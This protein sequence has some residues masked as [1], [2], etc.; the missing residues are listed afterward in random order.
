MDEDE[1]LDED[2]EEEEED[3]DIDESG[4]EYLRNAPQISA[5]DVDIKIVRQKMSLAESSLELIRV[6]AIFNIF[7][8]SIRTHHHSFLTL[9]VSE[10]QESWRKKAARRCTVENNIWLFQSACVSFIEE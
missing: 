9:T 10:L 1:I 8:S 6:S 2:C 3:D 7:H 4:P 5:T